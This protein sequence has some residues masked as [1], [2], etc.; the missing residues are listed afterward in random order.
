MNTLNT[1]AKSFLS[2]LLIGVLSASHADN[3]LLITVPKLTNSAALAAAQ[4]S[5]AFCKKKGAQVAV[6]VVGRDGQ[7]LV[8]LRDELA[9]AVT[10]TISKD[11]A[12]TA[13]FFET[14]TGQL[15]TDFLSKLED[16][17]GMFFGGGGE[18]L[19]TPAT[20]VGGIGVSGSTLD[21]D[22]N[23]AEAGAKYLND[24]LAIE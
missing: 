2:L 20:V 10:L 4:Q 7:I 16:D 6:T 3:K 23:C 13:M 12:Y 21:T 19:R 8:S 1:L 5:L 17:Y 24:E 18:P 9:A 22:A 15:K 14:P 11:K